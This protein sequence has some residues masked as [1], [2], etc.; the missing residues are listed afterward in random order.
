MIKSKDV[1]AFMQ[2]YNLHVIATIGE[3]GYV[4]CPPDVPLQATIIPLWVIERIIDVNR[5]EK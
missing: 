1:E 4:V 3:W 2:Q 5:E